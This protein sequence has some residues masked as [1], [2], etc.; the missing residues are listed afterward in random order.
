M[1]SNIL[2]PKQFRFARNLFGAIVIAMC[3]ATLHCIEYELNTLAIISFFVT[4][5]FTALFIS[6]FYMT[7][8]STEYWNYVEYVSKNIIS[9]MT[10]EHLIQLWWN[11]NK[12]L[13]W[14][15]GI[16]LN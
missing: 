11:R 7:Q 12:E 5:L 15:Y 4:V 2:K 1:K 13:F 6:S 3:F 8:A 10:Y 9:E 14:Y 16:S